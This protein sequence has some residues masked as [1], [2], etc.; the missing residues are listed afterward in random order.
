MNDQIW[1]LGMIVLKY[2]QLIIIYLHYCSFV[3]IGST[4]IWSRE[5]SN[6]LRKLAVLP[7]VRFE[8]LKLSLMSSYNRDKLIFLQKL[9]NS[10]VT[11]IIG[12]S[13]G[14]VCNPYILLQTCVVIHGICPTNIT[15]RSVQRNL[16]CSLYFIYLK[17]IFE[18]R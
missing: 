13:S 5:K 14:V 17:N 3:C 8:P 1:L 7:Y 15:K 16:L 6:H 10:F 11:E 12:A 2:F 18:V 9:F 4:V